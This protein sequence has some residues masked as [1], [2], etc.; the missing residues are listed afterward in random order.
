MCTLIALWIL[1]AIG[2][3][4]D[5]CNIKILIS[6]VILLNLVVFYIYKKHALFGNGN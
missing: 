6:V 4:P 5:V 1:V 2:L 3:L